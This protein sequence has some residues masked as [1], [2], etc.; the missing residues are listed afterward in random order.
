MRIIR[1]EANNVLRLSAV[2]IT[3]EGAMIC[4]GGENEAGKT[5]VL[6]AIEMALGGSGAIP[7]KPIRDGQE[8][9]KIVVDLGDIIVTRTFGASGTQ[10]VVT[11]R[12]GAVYRSPQTLLD[13]LVGKLSFDPLAFKQMDA[14]KQR[15]TLKA[16]VG[17]DLDPIEMRRAGIF[18]QRTDLNRRLKEGRARLEAMPFYADAPDA[19]V[20][21][22]ELV[23]QIDDA[24]AVNDG[25]AQA[26]QALAK[27]RSEV[28]R[29]T[30]VV[31]EI[32]RN[33]QRV[34]EELAAEQHR[35]DELTAAP[36]PPD[37]DLVGL[38]AKL[39]EA[40]SVNLKVRANVA[41]RD[42]EQNIRTGEQKA[43][44]MTAEIA[45]AE[46]EKT[47]LLAAAK[48]PVPGLAFDADGVTLDGIPFKQCSQGQ[49][50]RVSVA[51]GLAANPKLKVL[52]V[53]DGSLLDSKGLQLLAEMAAE[54]GAQVFVERVG[55]GKECQVIIE[56]GHVKAVEAEPATVA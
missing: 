50:L 45:A 36:L 48:F 47:A 53:R 13:A 51:I 3:P 44:T 20:I 19:E 16:L 2:E 4:I 21:L 42:Y 23:S 39:R 49:A 1:L 8:R 27:A 25:N 15:D 28:T 26:R 30:D 17:I 18:A 9:A 22:S 6:N 7:A 55:E 56:D 41:R 46:Q 40:E 37:A 32:E 54:A 11:S 38:Q 5:S 12:E 29:L 24:R 14:K 10:L 31:Q 34:R 52:L 33:L 35:V 43:E